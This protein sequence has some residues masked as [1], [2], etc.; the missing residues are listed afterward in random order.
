ML[1]TL[2]HE[3]FSDPDWIYERKLDGERC[4]VFR[5]NKKIRLLSRNKKQINHT[6]PDLV[7][8]LLKQKP[9]DFVIDGEIVAFEG[10]KTSFARLQNRMHLQ[11]EEEARRSSVKVDFYLFDMMHLEGYD[12]TKVSL[13]ARK[14]LLRNSISFDDPIRFTAHK[15]G[16]GEAFFKD[17]CKKGW[18]G[19]IA[20]KASAAYAHGRSKNWLKFKCINQQEFVIAGFTDP[21]GERIGFGA[22]LIGYYKNDNLKYA[23]KV[24]TGYDDDTLE[25]MSNRLKKIEQKEAPFSQVDF[26]TKGVHWVKPKFVAEV[27]FSEWTEDGKLRHPRY[28]GLRRDK[29]PKNVVREG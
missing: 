13:R 9:S 3:Q 10:N 26:S 25:E 11:S 22:L 24:G 2:S 6:Y 19:L 29:K 14:H 28:L 15:N 21:E 18:E 8:S 27:G 1:A 20:K 17:A 12:I 5:K 7:D 23:G 16:K 4:L